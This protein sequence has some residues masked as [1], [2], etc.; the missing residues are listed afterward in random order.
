[1]STRPSRDWM[2]SC[3]I[4]RGLSTRELRLYQS[5]TLAHVGGAGELGLHHAHSLAHVGGRLGARRGHGFG[6]DRVDLGGG[7]LLRQVALE[8][9]NLEFL[10]VGEILARGLLELRD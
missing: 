9:A 7:E 2:N 8:D 3:G 5:G 6:D 4:M 1:M 10:L